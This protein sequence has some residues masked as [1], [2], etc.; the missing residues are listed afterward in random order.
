MMDGA[1]SDG[2]LASEPLKGFLGW[3][4]DWLFQDEQP[5]EGSSERNLLLT[6]NAREVLA[7][8]V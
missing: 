5:D 7:A 6:L 1:R 8:K 4:S 3:A 2:A